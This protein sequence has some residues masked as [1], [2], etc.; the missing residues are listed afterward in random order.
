ML[1]T[2]ILTCAAV[3]AAYGIVQCG[4]LHYDYLGHRPQGHAR[5]LHDVLG[6]A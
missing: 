3:S 6:A 4:I 5:P 1:M 2:V